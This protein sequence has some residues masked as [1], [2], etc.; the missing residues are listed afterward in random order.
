MSLHLPERSA[1][2]RHWTLERPCGTRICAEPTFASADTRALL[3]EEDEADPA[4]ALWPLLARAEG[5]LVDLSAAPGLVAVAWASIAPGRVWLHDADPAA[6]SRVLGTLALN[7][8]DDAVAWLDPTAPAPMPPQGRAGAVVRSAVGA[9]LFDG[10]R[11]L[12]PW[13]Q[14]GA[15]ALVLRG[16]RDADLPTL[17]TLLPSGW[18]AWRFSAAVGALLPF[19]AGQDRARADEPVTLLHPAFAARLAEA[20]GLVDPEHRAAQGPAA[21]QVAQL[22]ALA[23]RGAPGADA[24]ADPDAQID[25]DAQRVLVWQA[26]GQTDVAVALARQV[27]AR[28]APGK[29][30]AARLSSAASLA[31]LTVDALRQSLQEFVLQ[32]QA[33]TRPQDWTAALA[34]PA[35]SAR[36]ERAALVAHM[37]S[38]TAPTPLLLS[39]LRYIA[40]NAVNRGIWVALLASARELATVPPGLA[41]AADDSPER[42]LAEL[43]D[44]SLQIVDVGASSLGDG[45]EPYAEL[46]RFCRVC[47]TGFEPDA[48]ALAELQGRHEGD[49]GRRYLPHFVGDGRA[50]TFHETNWSLT[51][52][53]LPPNRPVLDRYQNLGSL[54]MARAAHAVGTV[55]LDDVI[56]P[57]GMDLL[58][59]DVQGGEGLVFDGAQARLDECLLVWTEVEFLE[60]YRGQPLFGEIDRQLRA[61]GLQF[62]AFAGIGHRPLASWDGGADGVPLPRRFQQV[63]GDAIYLPTQERVA[64][65]DADRALRLALI[66][67][68]LLGAWDHC[69]AALLQFEAAGGCAGAAQAY[70]ERLQ[71]K[72]PKT[73]GVGAGAV[74]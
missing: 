2:G 34:S 67:H 51:G 22:L 45:T 20:E 46:A 6:R 35:H 23:A 14:A 59:I 52:S 71:R 40:D 66:T 12:E 44:P 38:N 62:Y 74:A 4:R 32:H 42:W 56:E 18:R 37:A 43:G 50:A 68:H 60:L 41:Q 72:A 39:R 29:A 30:S 16:L 47:V 21:R 17:G 69:H 15:S 57:G 65:L 8:L 73:A 24:G 63:W 48:T 28:C 27:L 61:R 55:R 5:P 58:K 31:G 7:Q 1:L 19:V 9:S 26:L 70:R 11:A 53:L 36:A 25:A 33:D 49:P 13:L 64:Q 3:V 54:T 10:W